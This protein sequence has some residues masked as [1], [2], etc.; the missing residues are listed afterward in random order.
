MNTF[1]TSRG[2]KGPKVDVLIGEESLS[3]RGKVVISKDKL[4][5]L[6]FLEDLGHELGHLVSYDDGKEDTAKIVE[7]K[8]GTLEETDTQGKYNDYLESLKEEYKNLKTEE[9]T[10]EWLATIS[11]NEKERLVPLVVPALIISSPIVADL[12]IKYGPIV[13]QVLSD[14]VFIES[15]QFMVIN[16]DL[17]AE[18]ALRINEAVKNAIQDGDK[19]EKVEES[20]ESQKEAEEIQVENGGSDKKPNFDKDKISNNNAEGWGKGSF[21][22]SERSLK[23][24]FERH[25][26]EVGAKDID[27]YVRKA[28]EFAKTAK[29][30]SRHWPVD[31]ETPD[32]TR[33]VKNGKYIDLTPK[34]DIISFGKYVP[35]N[36]K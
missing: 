25:G 6:S 3:T 20:K 35:L 22:S 18:V 27:Q 5:G 13:Y 33:Y 26:K 9:E 7:G 15:I 11:E 24:H 8:L 34:G 12:A 32:V 16:Q 14:P 1:L 19:I 30:N 21:E 36:K 2:Y 17:T 29:K 31:G 10:R 23:Y 28:K 4:N